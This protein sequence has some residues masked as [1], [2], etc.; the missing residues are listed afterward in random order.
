MND[1]DLNALIQKYKIKSPD[2]GNDLS[3][4]FK[5]NLMFGTHIG[6]A[7]GVQGFLRPETAQGHF[8]N[9]RRLLEFN[10]GKVPFASASLGL[11]FRNEISPRSGL[12]RVREFMMAEIEHFV[13]PNNKNHKKFCNIK[14]L[15]LPLWTAESQDKMQPVTHGVSLEE[16]VEK[17][18]IDNETLAYFMARTYLFLTTIGIR[19]EGV[20][21]RQHTKDEM[22]HYASDCWDAE[23]E[24]SYGWIEA[25][26]HADRTC[27]DLANH[28]KATGVE[29]VAA[30]TLPQLVVKTLTRVAMNKGNIYKTFKQQNKVIVEKLDKLSEFE[31]D[32]LYQEFVKTGDHVNLELNTGNGENTETVKLTKDFVTFEKYEHTQH[33][34]KFIPGV[35]EP[36]FGIGRIVYCVLEHAF[37]VREKDAKR[38]F[39]NFPAVVAPYKVS[40]IPLMHE[41]SMLQF[42]EPISMLIF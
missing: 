35:I 23:I 28:T 5:F 1:T 11:A 21:F 15:K 8:V 29:L 24:T 20:R 32:V 2:T 26:G 14:D 38:T 17:K 3:E 13:D 31:K 9:F 41:P 18:M 34:E 39:F 36:S 10:S 25:V 6:P 37:G 33:E 19:K 30:K 7:G 40:I 12:L 22:A 42:V 16:A 4:A 27:Y